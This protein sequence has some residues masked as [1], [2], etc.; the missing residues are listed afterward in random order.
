MILLKQ[1]F[2]INCLYN[3]NILSS[4]SSSICR[5]SQSPSRRK[6]GSKLEN[7]IELFG[8]LDSLYFRFSCCGLFYTRIHTNIQLNAHKMRNSCLYS[9]HPSKYILETHT[10]RFKC[11]I[12]SVNA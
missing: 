9:H 1:G 8:I 10:Q 12:H 6:S 4:K 11:A 2:R 5:L 3:T 7:R